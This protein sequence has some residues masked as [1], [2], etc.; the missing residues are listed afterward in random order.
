MT[1]SKRKS[2]KLIKI[3]YKDISIP[4]GYA[5]NEDVLDKIKQFVV[6]K[7]KVYDSVF[8]LF[9][10][11]DNST[12]LLWLKKDGHKYDKRYRS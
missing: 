1:I 3:I 2:S 10:Q 4:M 5:N 8:H 12:A 9:H 6:C 11:S 7:N